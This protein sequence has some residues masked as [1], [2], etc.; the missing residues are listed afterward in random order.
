MRADKS[1]IKKIWPWLFAAPLMIAGVLFWPD[2]IEPPQ[3]AAAAGDRISGECLELHIGASGRHQMKTQS[4]LG[5]V[6]V[7]PADYSAKHRYGLL[8]LFPPAGFSKIASERFYRIT[9]YATAAGYVVAFS[10]ALPLSSHAIRAQAEVVPEITKHWCIDADRIV[11]AGHSDG[12]LVAQGT[13]IK[14]Y[15][16]T[17]QGG[18]IVSSAAGI[19]QQDLTAEKCPTPKAVTL[20]HPAHD[21]RFPAYG[22]GVAKWWANCFACKPMTD[23]PSPGECRDAQVC[24]ASSSVRFCK[25][26]ESHAQYSPAF[27]QQLK[28]LM[29]NSRQSSN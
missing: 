10:D 8:M 15:L 18:S 13:V 11:L 16:S 6:V 22:W 2:G 12:G 25:T 20:L 19:Q 28:L 5:Y 26:T 29:Q 21:E 24:N 7:T 3:E 27:G 9:Q 23:E 1:T 17:T 14:A 4:G